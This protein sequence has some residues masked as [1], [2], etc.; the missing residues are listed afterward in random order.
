M[1]SKPIQTEKRVWIL[2]SVHLKHIA[3]QL[4]LY[5]CILQFHGAMLFLTKVCRLA[6]VG[7]ILKISI[8][9]GFQQQRLIPRKKSQYLIII[10]GEFI[11]TNQDF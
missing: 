9:A 1:L 6:T 5:H 3:I 2:K 8:E 7:A 11:K 4:R 10:N